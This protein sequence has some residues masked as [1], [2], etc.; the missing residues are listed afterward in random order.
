MLDNISN[1]ILMIKRKHVRVHITMINKHFNAFF[2]STNYCFVM[3]NACNTVVLVKSF[4]T[5]VYM[6]K[7]EVV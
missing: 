7:T 3:S 1:K 2:M 5:A 6:P 4:E